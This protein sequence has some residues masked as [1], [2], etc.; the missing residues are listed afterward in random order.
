MIHIPSFI[1]GMFVGVVIYAVG[2]LWI[3]YKNGL[4]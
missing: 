4:L 3:D 2:Q 1:L